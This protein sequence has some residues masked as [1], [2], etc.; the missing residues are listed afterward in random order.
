[1]YSPRSRVV[2]GDA[3]DPGDVYLDSSDTEAV[4]AWNDYVADMDA[5]TKNMMDY[6]LSFGEPYLTLNDGSTIILVP[7]TGHSYGFG[8]GEGNAIY[9]GDYFDMGELHSITFC[10]DEYI[11]E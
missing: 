11:F 3:T 9:I 10:G 4:D 6:V 5:Y 1:M 2:G 8:A 7:N